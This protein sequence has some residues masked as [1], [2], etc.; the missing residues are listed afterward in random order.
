MAGKLVLC[1]HGQSTWNK[2]NL[3]TGWHDVDLTE[4]GE[5]DPVLASFARRQQVFQWHEDGIG[6]PPGAVHLVSSPAS[7][8][9]AFR[10][11]KH[12]YGFQFHL[13]VDDSL[14]TRWLTVPENQSILTAEQ[15]TTDPRKIRRQTVHSIA[16][17]Q[18]LSQLTFSRWVDQF[19]IAPRRRTLPSR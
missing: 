3:F 14:I 10:Y 8:V 2:Q 12:A 13:E 4:A 15:S 18:S 6:L 1:R 7:P 5:T 17:L 16:D 11:G 9:Q 19:E